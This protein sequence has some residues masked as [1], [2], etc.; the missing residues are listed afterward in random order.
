MGI[1]VRQGLKTMGIQYIGLVVGMLNALWLFPYFI[2]PAQLGLIRVINDMAL[3][4][5]TISY[6]GI[7]SVATQFYPSFKN[8]EKKDQGFFMSIV[9]YPS[10][11]LVFFLTVLYVYQESIF[12]FYQEK[13]PLI[14]TYYPYIF[15]LIILMTYQVV[16]EV[17]SSIHQRTVFPNFIREVVLRLGNMGLI[18]AFGWG[19]IYLDAYLLGLLG[20][21]L[22][23]NIALIFYLKNLKKLFLKLDF[24]QFNG[25][26]IRKVLDY[27]AYMYIGGVGTSLI[28]KIDTLMLPVFASLESV[29]I[30]TIALTFGNV[31]EIP[32]KAISQIANPVISLTM[33]ARDYDKIKSIYRESAINLLLMGGGV[34]LLITTNIDD[35]FSLIPKAEIY[36]QGKYVVWIIAFSRLIDLLNGLNAEILRF[37]QY[38][39]FV[40][41]LVFILSAMTLLG[42]YILIP[43]YGIEGAA[44]AS[45]ISISTYEIIKFIFIWIKL[46]MQPFTWQTLAL[47][48][49]IALC[50]G[51]GIQIPNWGGE[52]YFWAF[53]NIGVRSFLIAGL[54]T[55]LV[56]GLRISPSANQLLEGIWTKVLERIK[57][58]PFK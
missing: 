27:T 24:S 13:S 1:I 45:L 35:V 17:Y 23:A 50:F 29:A 25:Q 16:F 3:I 11:G 12:G 30:Y 4:W 28:F 33:K 48:L 15:P 51:L 5:M 44:I 2:P 37:S 40:L 10:L 19:L 9:I 31:I 7:P 54:Y 52:N 39:R 58:P 56:L 14:L 8:S 21:F 53:I 49:I 32:R 20:L 34:F 36:S 55:V 22:L 46:K 47:V 41:V 6:L 18:L 43:I 26:L 38:Y 42:N 57:K